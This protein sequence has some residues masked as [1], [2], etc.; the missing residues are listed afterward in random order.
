MTWSV[1]IRILAMVTCAYSFGRIRAKRCFASASSYEPPGPSPLELLLGLGCVHAQ[2]AA[3]ADD[4]GRA[5][6][7]PDDL[8]PRQRFYPWRDWFLP[9]SALRRLLARPPVLLDRLPDAPRRLG[10]LLLRRRRA[11]RCALRLYGPPG[12][13]GSSRN[14]VL[15]V[16]ERRADALEARA[17]FDVADRVIRDLGGCAYASGATGYDASGWRAHFGE[18]RHARLVRLQRAVDP[19][20]LLRRPGLPLLRLSGTPAPQAARRAARPGD[21]GRG[22]PACAFKSSGGSPGHERCP[23]SRSGAQRSPCCATRPSSRT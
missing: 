2:L 21:C 23:A 3:D 18:A 6:L 4:I 12:R 17:R 20:G 7:L 15:P 11:H 9:W 1:C 5:G 16:F 13:T 10:R 19:A 14:S 8:F 22:M